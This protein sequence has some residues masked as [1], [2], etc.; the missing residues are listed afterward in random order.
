MSGRMKKIVIVLVGLL[1]IGF[2]N[3][4]I[5]TRVSWNHWHLP[6]SGRIIVID[7]GHGGPD[8][9]AEGGDLVEKNIALNIAQNLRDYLQEAGA[10]VIM[11]RDEDKDLAD[12]DMEGLSRRKT[13]D[14][15]RRAKMAD[16]ADAD[17]FITIHLNAIPSS[18]W[19]GAQTFYHPKSLRNKQLAAFIQDSLRSSLNNTN[20]QAKAIEHIY[21]LKTAK[22]PAALVEAG[23][24]S[25]PKE[26]KLLGRKSYQKKIS[27]AI[28]KGVLRFYTKEKP[29]QS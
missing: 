9:G 26:R 22:M 11:T 28:Y 29:P 15:K 14:L 20:R 23:F 12:K 25:N 17:L 10:L 19:H 16:Q 1:L 27:E 8:G 4:E 24:L 5:L 6:L 2:I 13:Q 21:L 18:R 3:Y 7:A